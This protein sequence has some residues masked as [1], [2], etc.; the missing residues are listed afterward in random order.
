MELIF[1]KEMLAFLTGEGGLSDYICT[2]L[3]ANAGS[4]SQAGNTAVEVCNIEQDFICLL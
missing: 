3:L 1:F 2:S 4:V